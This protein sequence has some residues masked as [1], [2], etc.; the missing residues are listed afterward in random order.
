[1]S[2]DPQDFDELVQTELR[3][4]DAGQRND[5]VDA[6]EKLLWRAYRQ[7]ARSMQTASRATAMDADRCVHQ[8]DKA[9]AQVLGF[10]MLATSR[11]DALSALL[12]FLEGV[13]HRPIRP[14][15]VVE[16]THPLG[17]HA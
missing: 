16:I 6:L 12:E 3:A 14:L 9:L 4:Y 17:G 10:V 1:M 13:A 7:A 5:I 15:K 8:Q 2:A 11:E